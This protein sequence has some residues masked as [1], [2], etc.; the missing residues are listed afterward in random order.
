M[1]KAKI[2]NRVAINFLNKMKMKTKNILVAMISLMTLLFTMNSCDE[3]K[4]ISNNDLPVEINE[5]IETHFSGNSILQSVIEL[6]DF[7]KTYEVLLEGNF[8]LKFN[9]KKEIIDIEGKTKLPD[10][11][12]PAKIGQYVAL[13]YPDNFI[14]G[15]E[16]EGRNQQIELDNDL[17]LEFTKGGDFIRIDS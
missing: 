11:V 3:E 16:I 7:T 12:I 13:N 2:P 9:R 17:D 8:K 6:D 15:W 4:V 14:I 5:Y 10:S 1:E